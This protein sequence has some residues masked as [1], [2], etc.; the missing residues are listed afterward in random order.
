MRPKSFELFEELRKILEELED[1]AEDFKSKGY[2]K[3]A[4]QIKRRAVTVE[5][6]LDYLGEYVPFKDDSTFTVWGDWD[7]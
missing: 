1:S 4:S 6:A 2:T 3:V 7:D 5:T